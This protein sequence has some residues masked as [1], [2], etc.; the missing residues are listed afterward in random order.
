MFIGFQHREILVSG[1]GAVITDGTDFPVHVENGTSLSGFPQTDLMNAIDTAGDLS[2]IRVEMHF[3]GTQFGV[4]PPG[5]PMPRT[6]KLLND[7]F[8]CP[9]PTKKGI[10]GSQM[11]VCCVKDPKF[12]AKK[13]E[14]TRF[15]P[16]RNGTLLP[17]TMNVTQSKAIFQLQV[18]K[19]PPD[20]NRTV[21]YPPQN[22]KINGFLN[23]DYTCGPPI[24]VSPMEFPDPSGLMSETEAIASW[25]IVCNI[26][27]RQSKHSQ[28]CVTYSAFYNESVVPCNTCACGCSED[29]ACNP[30]APALLLPPEALLVPSENRTAKAK[31][32][33]SIK[34]RH[35]PNT[36][37]CWD[38]CGVSINWHIVS[39][40]RKG[41][42]ARITLFNW[43]DYTFK[44]WFVALE[45]DKFYRGY[46]KVYSFNGTKLEGPGRLNRTIFLQGLKGLNYLIAE[47]DGKDPGVDPRVP[48]K[49]QSVIS[50]SKKET[51]GINIVK[52][53]G[54]PTRLYFNGE[55]CEL[56][57]E[58]PTASG[59][60]HSVSQLAVVLLTVV[61]LLCTV[62]YF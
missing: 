2:Q 37:P 42:T 32:W 4:K 13:P 19:L 16:R 35:L 11:Y 45:M 8:K 47:T 22:W 29:A 15:L 17:P 50:F 56:P 55:E 27:R 41:W 62:D 6:I 58:I 12:K 38:N 18:Y 60:R 39:N 52:G 30:D 44:N 3:T 14:T 1:S 7:G 25:Q 48:G 21:F 61:A 43:A 28:C 49:Q 46:E 31:A 5:T 9:A 54:F 59:A 36:L 26:T 24:R 34:H 57:D 10:L 53:D 51:P 23:P 33:A 20:L 40:Y